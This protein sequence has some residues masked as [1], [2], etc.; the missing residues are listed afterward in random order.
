MPYSKTTLTQTG[1]ALSLEMKGLLDSA[2]TASGKY[3]KVTNG[4]VYSTRT[5]D[6]WQNDGT[7]DGYTW[8]LVVA[9][10]TA[11]TGRLGTGG[12]LEYDDA[13][14]N[15]KKPLRGGSGAAFVDQDGY[16]LAAAGGAELSINLNNFT[17]GTNNPVQGLLTPTASTVPTAAASGNIFRVLVTGQAVWYWYGTVSAGTHCQGVGT[18]DTVHGQP[19]DLKPLAYIAHN[20]ASTYSGGSVW[21]HPSATN[22]TASRAT[23]G[24]AITGGTNL[25]HETWGTA[26]GKLGAAG[27]DMNYGPNYVGSRLHV[28]REANASGGGGGTNLSTTGWSLG[29]APTDFLVFARQGAVAIGDTINVGGKIYESISTPG[30]GRGLFVNTQPTV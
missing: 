16:P 18:Y 4:F 21:Q 13:T 17:F 30:A 20:Y 28:I 23:Y 10:D 27:T 25:E 26:V 12:A 19:W 22:A 29:L 24:N 8:Y 7:S 3:T 6:V 11:Q 9:T 5:M 15:A 2:L 1:N 14:K